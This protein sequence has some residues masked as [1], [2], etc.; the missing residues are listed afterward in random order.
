MKLKYCLPSCYSRYIYTI[1]LDITYTFI[2]SHT[3][4]KSIRKLHIIYVFFSSIK[5]ITIFLIFV[6]KYVRYSLID[7]L[8]NYMNR[9]F[10]YNNFDCKYMHKTQLLLLLYLFLCGWL[11]DIFQRH[12][13]CKPERVNIKYK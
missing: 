2:F 6:K 8:F 3:I 5:F 10:S 7:L 9:Q 11:I 4:L 13:T 12:Q 1:L